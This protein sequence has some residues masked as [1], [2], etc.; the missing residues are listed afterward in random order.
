MSM[1]R[2]ME[3]GTSTEPIKCIDIGT[4]KKFDTETIYSTLQYSIFCSYVSR[5]VPYLDLNT[6]SYHVFEIFC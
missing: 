3:L 6:K 1:L 5:N 4:S 2:D